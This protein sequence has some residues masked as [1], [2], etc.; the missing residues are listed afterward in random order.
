[1]YTTLNIYNYAVSLYLLIKRL[2]ATHFCLNIITQAHF[3][4]CAI[5]SCELWYS[6]IWSW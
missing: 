1:V 5:C 3:I 2:M 6:Y 4:L